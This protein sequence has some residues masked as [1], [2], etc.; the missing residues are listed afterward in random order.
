ME[1]NTNF[2]PAW[3][4][5]GYY[6]SYE[7]ADSVRNEILKDEKMQAKVRHRH[8]SGR[9]LVKTRVHPDHQEKKKGGK[10]SGKGKRRNKKNSEGGVTDTP[11]TV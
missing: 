5:H 11:T 7:E 8:A 4:N 2:N 10:K 1:V 9:F 6:S 3:K